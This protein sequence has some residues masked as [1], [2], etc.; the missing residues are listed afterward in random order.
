MRTTTPTIAPPPPPGTEDPA[1]WAAGYEDAAAGR[2]WDPARAGIAGGPT[3]AAE[4]CYR[5]GHHAYA[6]HIPGAK[7]PGS[8]PTLPAPPPTPGPAARNPD[9]EPGIEA[10]PAPGGPDYQ[11]VM[12]YT[13]HRRINAAIAAAPERGEIIRR[14]LNRQ[15]ATW[16]GADQARRAAVA[17][18]ATQR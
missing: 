8:K 12:T 2:L 15:Y 7:P 5:Q 11:V 3:T 18:A 14:A 10:R 9:R 17:F 6:G 1:A 4:R 16:H 13:F